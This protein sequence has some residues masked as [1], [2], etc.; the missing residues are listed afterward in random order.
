MN[1]GEMQFE[2]VGSHDSTTDISSAATLTKPAGATKIMLQAITE[3]CRVTFDGSD[4]TATHGFLI[5]AGNDPIWYPVMVGYDVKALE[6][7][8]T[9]ELQIQWGK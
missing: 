6:E 4:P 7:A 9:C 2:P 1:D 3:N 5:T 8:A